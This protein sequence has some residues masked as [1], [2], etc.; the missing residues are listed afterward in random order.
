LKDTTRVDIVKEVARLSYCIGDYPAAYKYYSKMLQLME[1][2]HL[3]LYRNDYLTIAI[4][5][6]KVGQRQ[7]AD[8]FLKQ[9]KNYIDQDKTMYKNLQLGMYYAHLGDSQ[10][11]IEH[12]RLFSKEDNFV[13]WALLLNEDPIMQYMKDMPEFKKVMGDIEA[14]FWRRNKQ[15]KQ[16]LEDKGLTLTTL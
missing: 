1:A 15:T 16:M 4:V 13:Y 10:K 5:Y 2:Q 14:N 11:S 12:L 6:K 7:K 9:F 8:E 3:D